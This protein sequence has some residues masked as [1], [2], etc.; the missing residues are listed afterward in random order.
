M[1]DDDTTDRLDRLEALVDRQAESIET[2]HE[3]VAALR[4]EGDDGSGRGVPVSR[5]TAL[6]AGGLLALLGI[7][8]GTASADP[9]GQVGT[10][11]DPL[12][13]LY[14][15][16][17]NSPSSL[18]LS[19]GGERVLELGVPGT[20]AGGDTAGGNVVAG[21]PNNTVNNGA[22]GVVIGGGG[23]TNGN[24]NTVGQR[25]ATVGGGRRNAGS[26]VAA[27]VGGGEANTASGGFATVG[28]GTGNTASNTTAT[29]GGG[30]HST[31]SSGFATVG[32]GNGNTASGIAA[33]VGGGS[34][35]TASGV[36]ATV[37]GGDDNTASGNHSFAAGQFGRAAHD[38]SFVWNDGSGES[39]A[40]GTQ[41]DQF[42]SGTSVG[43]TPTGSNT[44]HVKA[45]GG[46][47]F[48]TSE[49]NGSRVWFDTNGNVEAS[50]AKNF[51][52][53]VE[54]DD[55]ERTVTYTALEA[56]TAR[57]EVSGVATV[58]DGYAEVDLPEH[59]A[60]VTDPDEDLVVQVT[61]HATEAVSPQVT[62][63]TTDRLLIEDP[64]HGPDAYEVS[65]TVKGT[66]DGYADKEV[67][68]DAEG[69]RESE[70]GGPDGD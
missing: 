21:H 11:S 49:D 38:N 10:A 13:A 25:Y 24:E 55:G 36:A 29:V 9:Q 62:E 51:V 63:R 54:T 2:L 33:T 6:R 3:D 46:V 39:D 31:A 14:A 68:D 12:H 52:E 44:F 59:F 16:E 23:A 26:G 5:R 69:P 17:A 34:R 42:S 18:S 37:G 28:G 43:G 61:A 7:G 35:N 27:T 53:R 20:D 4:E 70:G 57:T 47:R 15:L 65:Y 41:N 58:A 45:T 19:T 64:G 56:P 50:G 32:G 1:T 67:V 60:W 22:V 8:A 30:S 66:R 48:I 40:V